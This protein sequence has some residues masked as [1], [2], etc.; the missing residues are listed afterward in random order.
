MVVD[1]E[2]IDDPTGERLGMRVHNAFVVY[3]TLATLRDRDL[4][5]ETF[6]PAPASKAARSGS[7]S[8]SVTRPLPGR[9]VKPTG[10]GCSAGPFSMCPALRSNGS[11]AGQPP[12]S[13]A[14]A[15]P[16][17]VC[18]SAAAAGSARRIVVV[19]ATQRYRAA[20]DVGA[21]GPRAATYTGWHGEHDR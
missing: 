21:D 4:M 1:I 12:S 20:A 3:T 10:V 17:N 6:G 14:A 19:I 9:G 13:T 2:T 15:R 18:R 11:S 7:R 16:R 8:T 5:E